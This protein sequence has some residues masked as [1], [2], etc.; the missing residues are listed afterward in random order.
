MK[1]PTLEEVKEKFKDAEI[2][3]S[4]H[5]GWTGKINIKTIRYDTI[6]CG[7]II[8]DCDNEC[9]VTTLWGIE[10]GYAKILTY[11][12]P[13]FEITKE[14][15]LELHR[16]GHDL[17]RTQIQGIF[18]EVFKKEL[19]VGKWHKVKGRNIIF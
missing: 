11:K 8:C 3:E 7:F 12:T 4:L 19:V 1:K 17:T 2:V 13:K 5:T 18:P 10:K 16:H 15:V 6:Q 14:Q 9:G